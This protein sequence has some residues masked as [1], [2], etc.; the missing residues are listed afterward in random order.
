V[1]IDQLDDATLVTLAQKGNESAF[2]RLY[3]RHAGGVARALSSFAGAD[4][5]LL[6]D[7]TQDV[8]FR[9]IKALKSYKASF[10][11]THWLYTI[12]LNV[13]R[14]HARNHKRVVPITHDELE[15]I[16]DRS[17][18]TDQTTE[19]ELV[20]TLTRMVSKLPDRLRE[21]TSLRTGAGMSYGEI[22]EML[23]IPEGTARSRMHNAVIRLRKLT[24]ED[25]PVRRKENE[26]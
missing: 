12:A 17:R 25:R 16:A 3:D 21:I 26:R 15:N 1:K 18:R 23:G 10:P 2:E 13:G 6:D 19:D 5:D 7:L 22:A 24:G 20:D 9:V 14:N 11:F 4:R 8:F